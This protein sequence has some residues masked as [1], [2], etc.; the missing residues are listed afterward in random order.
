MIECHWNNSISLHLSLSPPPHEN[1][2]GYTS[3]DG[4]RSHAVHIFV[5]LYV[6]KGV[7]NYLPIIMPLWLLS[8]SDWILNSE[9]DLDLIPFWRSFCSVKALTIKIRSGD[10]KPPMG[11]EQICSGGSKL[12][13][14][15]LRG[16][17]W[18]EIK[19]VCYIACYISL[20]Y[21]FFNS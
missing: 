19:L 10:E 20:W 3:V 5:G 14:C 7:H 18:P 9:S 17:H 16:S 12:C 8:L 15:K 4:C 1:L 11:T 21:F 6:L 13:V 2:Q